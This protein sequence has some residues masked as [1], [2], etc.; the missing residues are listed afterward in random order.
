MIQELATRTGSQTLVVLSM[1]LFIAV[2]VGVI[3]RTVRTP[4]EDAQA[5]GRLPLEDDDHAGT[6]T[7]ASPDEGR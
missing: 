2:F 5:L 6:D 7:N 1:L 3:I 4:R